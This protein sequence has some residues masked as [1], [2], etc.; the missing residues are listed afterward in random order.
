MGDKDLFNSAIRFLTS[1]PPS[2]A[3]STTMPKALAVEKAKSIKA[4][5]KKAAEKG[6]T[7]P[8]HKPAE[9]PPE[10]E[11]DT[12]AEAV[13]QSGFSVFNQPPKEPTVSKPEKS[14]KQATDPA[15]L[16]QAKAEREAKAA[17]EKQR[18]EAEKAEKAAERARAKAEKEAAAKA[19]KTEKAAERAAAR[20]AKATTMGDAAPMAALRSAKDSY[21]RASN[22]RMRSTDAVASA[23]DKLE[24]AEAIAVSMQVLQLSENPYTR[25]NVGQQSMN[26]RNKVRAAIRQGRITIEALTDTVENGGFV[27][28][29]EA[30]RASHIKPK[31]AA[32]E[33]QLPLV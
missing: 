28:R 8:K 18:K 9:P 31:K 32:S 11:V 17:A 33:A 4:A 10:T 13:V 5:T 29:S 20:E 26:L 30:A 25:L 2:Y 27:A 16:A 6:I 14:T 19:E 7:K 3:W 21:V 1:P 15:L 24:P 12:P 22:G 23:F